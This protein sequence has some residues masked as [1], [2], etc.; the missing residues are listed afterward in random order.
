MIAKVYR[1]E[2]LSYVNKSHNTLTSKTIVASA[3][4]DKQETMK[5]LFK[6]ACYAQGMMDHS[7]VVCL[8]DGAD[9]C[10]SIAN[11]IKENCLKVT[12][13]LD[14]HHIAMKFRNIAISMEH[15]ELYEKAKWNLWHGRPEKAI[16]RLDE[17]IDLL[18]EDDLK[19]KLNKL[20]NYIDNNKDKIV[21][22]DSRKKEGLTYTSNQAEST[23]NMLINNRHKGKQKML[24]SRDGAHN[25]LQIRSS[26][27]SHSTEEDWE[28]I[29]AR[30]YKNAA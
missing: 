24:W 10:W 2:S 4:D 14:W 28:K 27:F 30:L 16:V 11:S 12:C 19:N 25:V 22:Y 29:E 9:N 5:K 23:V 1:P 13:I 7:E 8:A 20:K 17:L 21:N 3:K 15:Q 18:K 6:N 26:V